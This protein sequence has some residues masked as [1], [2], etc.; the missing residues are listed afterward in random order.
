M[1]AVCSHACSAA[2]IIQIAQHSAQVRHGALGTIRPDAS[3]P[4]TCMQCSACCQ[5]RST[6]HMFGAK[7]QAQRAKMA[8][9]QSHLCASQSC[10]ASMP[11]KHQSKCHRHQVSKQA[12]YNRQRRGTSH[13]CPWGNDSQWRNDSQEHRGMETACKMQSVCDAAAAAA[14]TSKPHQHSSRHSSNPS[15]Q[16]NRSTKCPACMHQ[17][18]TN[19]V[20]YVKAQDR[21]RTSRCCRE[22][23]V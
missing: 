5:R 8:G 14:V 16:C 10:I 17:I 22:P 15:Q 7:A 19:T 2:S 6:V 11:T 13:A 20:R 21:A 9:R 12:P 18:R 23:Y 4:L 3:R 1:P